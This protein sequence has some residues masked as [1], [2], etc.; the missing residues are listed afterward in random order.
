ML[1][2]AS[3]ASANLRWPFCA[4]ELVGELL[5]HFL[6]AS[7][8]WP[9]AMP[10]T[11]STWKPNSL[12]T[13]CISFWPSLNAASSNGFTIMPRP[14]QP[15]SPPFSAE[16]GSCECFFASSANRLGFFFSSASN[17]S[18][19]SFVL[20][21]MWLARRCSSTLNC[22][23]ARLVGGLDLGLG[24]RLLARERLGREHHVL[25]AH[26]L[27]RAELGLVGV[28]V[29][30]DLRVVDLHLRQELLRR[31]AHLGHLALLR[32]ERGERAATVRG[33]IAVSAIAPRNAR[34]RDLALQL[35]DV[36]LVGDALRLREV[37]PSTCARRELA[38]LLEL[39]A[40]W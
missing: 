24:R 29:R 1:L 32:L 31:D 10:V 4:R 6:V 34:E 18:A 40:R 2:K 13:T 14:N 37:A 5:A 15:R 33:A 7:A 21:R 22:A 36:A 39:R 8:P 27:R 20:T 35:G 3:A 23:G 16:P 11:R 30:L 9:P 17:L 26:A 28:V 38:V 25:G 12:S 19:S